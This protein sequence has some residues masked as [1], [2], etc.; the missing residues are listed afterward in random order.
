MENDSPNLFDSEPMTVQLSVPEK[1]TDDVLAEILEDVRGDV[2]EENDVV[3]GTIAD[4]VRDAV[5]YHTDDDDDEDDD[6]NHDVNDRSAAD[7]E[8][9]DDQSVDQLTATEQTDGSLNTQAKNVH[10]GLPPGRVKLIMKMDPDVNIVAG[11]AVY[12]LTK[13]T[14]SNTYS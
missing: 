9:G 6:E 10:K 3:D 13:A 7:Q 12:I 1:S 4:G 2:N 5:E 8:L 11:D 14:V